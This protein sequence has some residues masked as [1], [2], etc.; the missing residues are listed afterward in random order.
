VSVSVI[1]TLNNVIIEHADHGLYVTTSNVE[2]NGLITND[3]GSGVT[4][5]GN[6]ATFTACFFQAFQ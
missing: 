3:A 2:V 5:T 4:F 1:Q 6:N